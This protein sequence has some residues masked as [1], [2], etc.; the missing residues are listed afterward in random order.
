[1]SCIQ[2]TQDKKIKNKN[3]RAGSVGQRWDGNGAGRQREAEL[4]ARLGRGEAEE[5]GCSGSLLI[6]SVL[7]DKG[8]AHSWQ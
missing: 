3:G 7:R 4:I 5:E 1:M 2:F 8:W 6:W